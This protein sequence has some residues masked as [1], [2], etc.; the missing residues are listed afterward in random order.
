MSA[1]VVTFAAGDLYRARMVAPHVD[2]TIP[3]HRKTD[4]V[5]YQFVRPGVVRLGPTVAEF[6]E[7]GC[8]VTPLKAS[9]AGR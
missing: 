1:D 7:A 8:T 5:V 9:E 6:R 2:A 4:R 3:V